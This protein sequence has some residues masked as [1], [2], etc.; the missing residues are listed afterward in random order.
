MRVGH[1]ELPVANPLQS[2]SF[3][4]DTLG[5]D[6]ESNQG[7]R[8]IWIRCGGVELL[9]KPAGADPAVDPDVGPLHER[10]NICIYSDGID[11]EVARLRAAGVDVQLGDGTCYY[12]RDPDGHQFQLVDPSDHG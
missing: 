5:F 12:F 1:I 2:M 11:A 6:L 4:V 7:D 3:Y 8:F 10:R 9:L